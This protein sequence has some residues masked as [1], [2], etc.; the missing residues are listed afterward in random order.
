MTTKRKPKVFVSFS[1]PRSKAVALQIERLLRAVLPVEPW[2]SDQIGEGEIWATSIHDALAES[3]FGISCVTQENQVNPWILFEAGAIGKQRDPSRWALYLIDAG[4][5]LVGPLR[6]YQ[7]KRADR[8]GTKAILKKMATI[9]RFDW[10]DGTESKFITQWTKLQ[11]VLTSVKEK[12]GPVPRR[13]PYLLANTL[14]IEKTTPFRRWLRNRVLTTASSAVSEIARRE[15]FD[16]DEFRNRIETQLDSHVPGTCIAALCADKRLGGRATHIYFRKFYR[17]AKI[18]S[19]KERDLPMPS[20]SPT[21]VNNSANP[22]MDR[23]RVCRIFVPPLKPIYEK[24]IKEHR[25]NREYGVVPLVIP[26]IHKSDLATE[27]PELVAR[28]DE[29]FGFVVFRSPTETTVITHVSP[30]AAFAADEFTNRANTEEILRLFNQL[31]D[32][33]S[34]KA[35][36]RNDPLWTDFFGRLKAHLGDTTDE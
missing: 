19:E 10:T 22:W 3:T 25:D 11:R 24:V 15:L 35:F 1:G 5:E 26:S 8:S 18:L 17:W 27:Y 12:P 32:Y 28:L 23:I 2:T 14:N 29:G 6:Y 9:A 33:V 20:L 36:D 30:K 7:A 31:C 16:K 4:I 13:L 34:D 21:T